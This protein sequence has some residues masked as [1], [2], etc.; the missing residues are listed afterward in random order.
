MASEQCWDDLTQ[1]SSSL[2]SPS[3]QK[4]AHKSLHSVHRTLPS[5]LL[6]T[7]VSRHA[8]AKTHCDWAR[9]AGFASD[10]QH[11]VLFCPVGVL[12]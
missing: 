6:A 4:V 11:Q 1:L 12:P 3:Q 9:P 7:M 2:L 5:C 8:T 10:A